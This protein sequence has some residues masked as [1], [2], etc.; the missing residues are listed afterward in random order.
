LQGPGEGRDTLIRVRGKPLEPGAV[1]TLAVG[2]AFDR[3]QRR[4]DDR[5]GVARRHRGIAARTGITRRH[6]GI[7]AVGPM[8][9]CGCSSR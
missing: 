6:R 1:A 4:I 3:R 9:H 2:E 5:S 7:G 8:A